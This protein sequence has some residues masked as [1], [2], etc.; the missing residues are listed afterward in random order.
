MNCCPLLPVPVGAGAELV[1]DVPHVEVVVGCPQVEEVVECP[2][3]EE[4]V[5][6]PQEEVVVPQLGRAV[7]AATIVA[8]TKSDEGA[9]FDVWGVDE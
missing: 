3:V 2:Q 6:C 4:V 1:L 8:K 7:A 5:G 9:I